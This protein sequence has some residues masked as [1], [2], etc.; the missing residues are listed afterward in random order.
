MRRELAISNDGVSSWQKISNPRKWGRS[1][2]VFSPQ[3]RPRHICI[4]GPMICSL[5]LSQQKRSD[6]LAHRRRRRIPQAL[7]RAEW[8]ASV[9]QEAK[10]AGPVFFSLSRE[11]NI[12]IHKGSMKRNRERDGGLGF[13]PEGQEFR[14]RKFCLAFFSIASD[15]SLLCVCVRVSNDFLFG[16]SWERG[17]KPVGLSGCKHQQHF[18]DTSSFSFPK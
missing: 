8:R 6:T 18:L 17:E 10:Q 14:E 12:F 16:H 1:P 3:T 11:G 5:F 13:G 7:A 4:C 2:N 9:T 15:P